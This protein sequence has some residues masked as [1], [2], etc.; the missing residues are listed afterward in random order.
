MLEGARDMIRSLARLHRALYARSHPFPTQHTD[1][2]PPTLRNARNLGDRF[3]L[4]HAPYANLRYPQR[5]RDVRPLLPRPGALHR[6]PLV[7]TQHA[8]RSLAQ[9]TRATQ[10]LALRYP[11]DAVA[12]LVHADVAAITEHHLVALLR[13]GRPAH[14]AD[15]VLVVLDAQAFLV[16]QDGLDLVPAAQLELLD[17]AL[18]LVLVHG[19]LAALSALAVEDAQPRHIHLVQ[20]VRT[21]GLGLGGGVG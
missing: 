16:P 8:L 7:R 18:E 10:P 12:G 6:A 13:V 11:R 9:V 15:H 3:H 19:L 21:G 2:R 20:V 1:Q 17:D 4:L 5:A 14:V